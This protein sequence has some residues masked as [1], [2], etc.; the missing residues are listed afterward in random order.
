MDKF[1]FINPTNTKFLSNL[2]N[3]YLQD[4]NQ[5]DSSW[6]NFFKG[7]DLAINAGVDSCKDFIS[8]IGQ[9]GGNENKEQQQNL[10][11][12][13]MEAEYKVLALIEAYRMRGHLFTN[14]N[15][16]QE[17]R[18]HE[19]TLEYSQF[20]LVDKDLDKSF[21]V[22]KK[23][24]LGK[25]TL[26]KI[27]AH[28]Q[29]L[30]CKTIA[31]EY[32]HIAQP[33][34]R[35]WLQQQFEALPRVTFSNDE[36]IQILS[37]L[38]E[39]VGL[40]SFLNTKFVGQK[41]FSLEGNEAIIPAMHSLINKAADVHKVKEVVMGIS[42]RGRVNML[43][44]I[45][46]KSPADVFTEFEGKDY[47]QHEFFDG[48]V[49]YHLGYSVVQKTKADNTI[50]LVVP[51]NPSHL[52][53][54]GAVI[55]GMTRA[56]QDMVYKDNPLQ[57]LPILFHG[58]AAIA[59]QGINFE[60]VQ[61]AKL[62]GYSTGGT[63][64]VVINNQVGFTTDYLDSRSSIYA[65]DVAKVTSAP[66]LH[67]NADDIEAVV[68][69]FEFALNY[70]MHFGLD[71]FIDVLGYRKYGHNEADEPRFTQPKLYKN[72]AQHPNPKLIYAHKLMEEEIINQAFLSVIEE[73]F[74][75]KLVQQLA[76]AR[77]N[78]FVNI[79]PFLEEEWHNFKHGTVNDMLQQV[80]TS[81]ESSIMDNIASVLTELPPEKHFL[82]K[83]TKLIQERKRLYFEGKQV[84][85]AM[86]ELLAY[87]SLLAEGFNVRI[88]GQD[89]ERGT[90][91]HRHA[92]L[93]TED[94]QEAYIPLRKIGDNSG[95][96]SIYNS[97]LSEYAVL[98]FDY[99]YALQQPNCLTIWEAQFGDFA[100][101]AQIVIDNYIVAAEDKWNIH[102]GLVLLLPH[103]YEGQGAEHSSGR[104]ERFLQ[105]SANHNIY[106]CNCTTPA[107]YFHLLRRQMKTD[108]RKPLVVFTP[109]SLLRNKE[110]I[111]S[112]DELEREHFQEIIDDLTLEKDKVNTLVFCSGKFYYDLKEERSKRNC[113]TMA[114][115]RIEQLFPL[116]TDQLDA[117]ISS[118]PKV[119]DIV[120]AQ[121]EPKNMG[122]YAY[123]QLNYAKVKFRLA[124][125]Q[126]HSAPASG[127]PSRS[128]SRHQ[129]V[130]D[131]VFDKTVVY[132]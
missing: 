109:K 82:A 32:M 80:D 45:F 36:K 127:S 57:V 46:G 65:T 103:G 86:G 89:V 29:D 93:T 79:I 90:F 16:I 132:K 21:E 68:K 1:S 78:H 116:A 83:T 72:I 33:S 43:V 64:H 59:G 101:G 131:M 118:Y 119:N 95:Q 123:V 98:G 8:E 122:A 54:V 71:I 27:I 76:V 114:L 124:A 92:V 34:V 18:K 12:E 126:A 48:D 69:A 13:D 53:T 51:P 97:L 31:I 38:N 17:R 3:D 15:P 130:I 10:G 6:A 47:E 104:I 9:V 88:S 20:G 41:R 125:Q 24:G 70:R 96:F 23:L 100:N 85:W 11:P 106:V 60:L 128:K 73:Q 55:E 28:L 25:A 30:Y 50:R 129:R 44:N 61:M 121:E 94:T 49:K 40:E 19:A 110:V 14:T 4:P 115:I 87:G 81:V 113:N 102:N 67:V 105:L 5:V 74:K 66:V 35:N 91:S 120:W 108:F 42:H 63:I 58:D 84:D 99:G 52:E 22:G 39:A 112:I 2:Y 26:R 56:Q 117:L 37:H 111:S 7:F 77:Q 62:K 107:N 75:E